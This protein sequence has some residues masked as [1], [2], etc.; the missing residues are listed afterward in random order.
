MCSDVGLV[1]IADFLGQKNPKSDTTFDAF[2]FVVWYCCCCY[3]LSDPHFQDVLLEREVFP[4]AASWD[5]AKA[6]DSIDWEIAVPLLGRIGL[7]PKVVACL[8]DMWRHQRRW[9]SLGGHVHPEPLLGCRAIL[10][11]DP[12]GPLTLA[13]LLAGPLRRASELPG[14]H[15]ICYMDDRSA[16]FRTLEDLE[17]FQ[18][19]WVTVFE[20]LTRLR[21]NN[22]KT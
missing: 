6:F 5:F 15:C 2:K 21:T 17:A 19:Q 22:S 10:Q 14:T 4:I 16:L 18:A 11:G 12:F 7:P 20:R 1:P 3:S 9:I 13:C 8:G